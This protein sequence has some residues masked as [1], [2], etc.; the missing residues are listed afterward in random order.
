MHSLGSEFYVYDPMDY[1]IGRSGGALGSLDYYLEGENLESV[2]SAGVL[3][4][5]YFRGS[6]IDELV[7]GYLTGTDGKTHP[8]FFHHDQ[9]N[10]VSAVSGHN[11]GTLQATSY[12]AFGSSAQHHRQQS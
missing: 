9:D 5:K 4:E 11:G 12:A 2:Y 1:R 3:K 6:S 8:Y 7:A 10:S